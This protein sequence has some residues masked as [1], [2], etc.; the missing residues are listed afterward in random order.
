MIP[1]R[2]KHVEYVRLSRHRRSPLSPEA[3]IAKRKRRRLERR[4]IRSGRESD[5]ADFRRCCRDTIR[6]INESRRHSVSSRLARCA[7]AR[8]RWSA[9]RQLLHDDNQ[10]ARTSVL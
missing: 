1:A 4:W 3:T 6:L 2:L 7:N 9:V 5:K 8:Q 10:S